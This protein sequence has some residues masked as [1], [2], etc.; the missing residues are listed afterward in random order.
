VI[1]HYPNANVGTSHHNHD[2]HSDA[3][4]HM[5]APVERKES[6]VERTVRFALY[7]HIIRWR[8]TAPQPKPSTT[9]GLHEGHNSS[10]G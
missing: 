10:L 9:I 8:L 2:G 7:P 5:M 3:V 4:R 6:P 1:P